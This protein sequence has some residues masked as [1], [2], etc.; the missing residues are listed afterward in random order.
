MCVCVCV[1]VCTRVR[2]LGCAGGPKGHLHMWSFTRRTHNIQDKVMLRVKV[3][4]SKR[5]QSQTS[6]DKSRTGKVWIT[7]PNPFTV[8]SRK[9]HA[10]PPAVSCDMCRVLSP[11][12]AHERLSIQGFHCE[13]VT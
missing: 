11:R 10:V 13:L 1:Y 2:A 5:T 12:E 9:T 8:Q 3:Y 7:F 6:K 4:Y